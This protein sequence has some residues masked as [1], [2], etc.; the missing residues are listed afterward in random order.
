M[1]KIE[2]K[3]LGTPISWNFENR[4]TDIGKMFKMNFLESVNNCLEILEKEFLLISTLINGDLINTSIKEEL[5][6]L[7]E[8]GQ[9][10]FY[11]EGFGR[12]YVGK[13]EYKIQDK[14]VRLDFRLDMQDISISTHKNC[15]LPLHPFPHLDGSDLWNINIYNRNYFRLQNCLFEISEKLNWSVDSEPRTIDMDEGI[16]IHNFRLYSGDKY[17]ITQF[18]ED[19]PSIPFK[20]RDALIEPKLPRDCIA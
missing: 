18:K 17:L 14:L 1:R 13:G 9:T 8:N 3:Y 12:V 15:W 20:I 5:P 6:L 19:R 4:S 11:I 16:W 7:V 10:E 2:L